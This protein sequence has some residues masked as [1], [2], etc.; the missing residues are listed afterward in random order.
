MREHRFHPTLQ[1]SGILDPEAANADR[2]GH[3]GEVG[4]VEVGIIVEIAGGLHFHGDEAEHA[5]VEHH[6]LDRQIELPE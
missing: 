1:G 3:G 4:I 6:Q 5:I 2:L